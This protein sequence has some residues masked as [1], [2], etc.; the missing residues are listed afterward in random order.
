MR[1]WK[2]LEVQR[3]LTKKV[4]I[5][6]RQSTRFSLESW[7]VERSKIY[8]IWQTRNLK[9][10]INNFSS[11]AKTVERERIW[12]LLVSCVKSPRLSIEKRAFLFL[13]LARMCVHTFTSSNK[14][15]LSGSNINQHGLVAEQVFEP[16]QLSYYSFVE[17]NWN[18]SEKHDM[19]KIFQLKLHSRIPKSLL[20]L[21]RF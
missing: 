9:W 6:I 11:P 3:Q 2:K 12:N 1:R 19:T 7:A 4:Q 5:S 15:F 16:L 21:R 18:T 8:F 10:Q 17:L 13:S 20:L 14:P